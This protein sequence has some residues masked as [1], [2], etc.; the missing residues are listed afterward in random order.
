MARSAAKQTEQALWPGAGRS[1]GRP[2]VREASRKG[3]LREGGRGGTLET[4]GAAHPGRSCGD[5]V[6]S[7][8]GKSAL[9][10]VWFSGVFCFVLFWD[11]QRLERPSAPAPRIPPLGGQVSSTLS[12]SSHGLA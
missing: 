10:G 4:P 5:G 11:R 1:S 3:D 8:Q 6:K 12:V 7:P 2:V 9:Q